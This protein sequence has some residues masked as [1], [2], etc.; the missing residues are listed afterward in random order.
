VG[1]RAYV[2]IDGRPAGIID[3]ADQLRAGTQALV[4]DLASL[5]ITRVM[6]LSGDHAANARAI[7]TAV[8]IGEVIGD[9]LPEDKTEVVSGLVRQGERVL[10]VGDGTND[11]PALSAATVGI[12]V[13]AHGGGISAEAAD[14]VLLTEDL[15]RVTRVIRVAR[16]T[17]RIA[18]QSIWVGIGLSGAAMVV[19]AAGYI[20]PT[21]GALIQEAIDVAVIVNAL[22]AS[23]AP[24]GVRDVSAEARQ[25]E[26]ASSPYAAARA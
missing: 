15:T 20:P 21:I 3:F 11:A 6:L 5:G 16:R 18:R 22:R 12:A 4:S 14:A 25:G 7:A 2:V 13:A 10:M 9:M 8:G 1:L 26:P 17:M 23:R 19:A 24:Y